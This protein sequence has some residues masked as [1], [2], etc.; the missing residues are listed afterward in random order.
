MQEP[1][2]MQ[3][4]RLM[5]KEQTARHADMAQMLLR[6]NCKQLFLQGG[7]GAHKG[8]LQLAT[9]LKSID[10]EC[11]LVAVPCTVDNDLMMVDTSFGFDTACTEVKL[12]GANSGF[13]AMNATMAARN[14]DICWGHS[15]PGLLPEMEIDLEKV[16]EH[17]EAVMESKGYAV[18]VV[19]AA[20]GMPGRRGSLALMEGLLGVSGWFMAWLVYGWF[21]VGWV[22][23]GENM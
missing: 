13:L 15:E 14:V 11:A 16:L 1:L 10:H 20:Q 18:I 22:K 9:V 21:M 6:R 8:A 4:V 12:L 3:K 17:C 2:N 5:P 23:N 7:D 19:R